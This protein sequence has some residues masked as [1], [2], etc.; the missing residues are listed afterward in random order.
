MTA[1]KMTRK[2]AL[3]KAMECILKNMHEEGARARA[4]ELKAVA[5]NERE[6]L[7]DNY[8]EL[9]AA[10]KLIEHMARQKELL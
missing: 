5:K 4:G 1:P 8:A 9:A 7:W 2:R 10:L 3:E 6:G